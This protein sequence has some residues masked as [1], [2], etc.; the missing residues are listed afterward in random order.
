MR[1]RHIS[2]A[3]LLGSLLATAGCHVQVDKGKNGEDKNVRI[4]TPLGGVHVRSDQTAATDLGLPVYPGAQIAPDNDGDK[5]ADVHLGFGKWQMRVRVVSYQTPDPQDKVLAFYRGAM[6]RFGDVIECDG[7]QPVGQPT[8]TG[9]GL[10]CSEE[11][12]GHTHISGVSDDGGLSLR[13]GSRRHQHIFSVK[14]SPSGTKFS[15]VELQLPL[16]IDSSSPKTSD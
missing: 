3:F 12:H 13:A 15:L 1:I 16:D 14:S 7:N 6:A 11:K 2:G 4:E 8:V 10:T 9:E 5:S